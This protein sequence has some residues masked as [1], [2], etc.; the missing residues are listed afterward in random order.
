MEC[1]EHRDSQPFPLH[2]PPPTPAPP[3][4]EP[5]WPGGA[6]GQQLVL[7]LSLQHHCSLTGENASCLSPQKA[8]MMCR[9]GPPPLHFTPL[10]LSPLHFLHFSLL[11]PS[12]PFHTPCC[13]TL[14]ASSAELLA[15]LPALSAHLHVP[16]LTRIHR[17]DHLP[18]EVAQDLTEQARSPLWGLT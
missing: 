1:S 8:C 16:Q 6:I 13:F 11:S 18:R 14:V 5:R 12:C 10:H 17:L 4:P 15:N 7:V 9:R 2:P 3:G